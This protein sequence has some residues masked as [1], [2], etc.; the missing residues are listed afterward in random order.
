DNALGDSYNA[1]A[2]SSPIWSTTPRYADAANRIA[3]ALQN[4]GSSA[5]T[6]GATQLLI[7]SIVDKNFSV[8]WTSTNNSALRTA[9]IQLT[10][11]MSTSYDSRKNYASA[12]EFL[13][14]VHDSTNTLHQDLA[15]VV[16]E[17]STLAIA[18]LGALGFL[19]FGLRG[20]IQLLV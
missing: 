6:R 4:A 5:I 15:F 9:T 8:N 19:G 12:V 7:W 16:P 10:A 13:S 11:L 1:N 18:G 2:T 17:P 14:A 20:R 3:W